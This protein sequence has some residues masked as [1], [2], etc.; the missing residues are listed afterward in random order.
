MDNGLVIYHNP[1]KVQP[2]NLIHEN[3]FLST[4]NTKVVM[5]P[6]RNRINRGEVEWV[7]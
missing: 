6:R 5:R 3:L 7:I 2:H 1:S 4:A